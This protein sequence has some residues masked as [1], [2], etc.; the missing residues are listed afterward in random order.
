MDAW[1]GWG[2][3]LACLMTIAC[4]SGPAGPDPALADLQAIAA[5]Q[6]QAAIDCDCPGRGDLDTCMTEQDAT[7]RARQVA[8]RADGLTYDPSCAADLAAAIEAQGCSAP[9]TGAAHP[10]TSYCAPFHGERE[11]GASCTR[12]D[13]LVSDCAQGLTCV[14][15]ACREPCQVFTGLRVGEV[16]SDPASGESLDRCAEGLYCDERCKPLAGP[17]ESCGACV[18]DYYCSY[19]GQ[20]TRCLER[21]DEGESCDLA[22]C[23]PG[24]FCDYDGAFQCRALANAGE[25]CSDRPCVDGLAC[26]GTCRPPVGEGESCAEAACRDGLLCDYATTITCV[27]PPSAGSPCISD[28]CEAS[29]VCDFETYTCRLGAVEGDPCTGHAQ[30]Q[31]RYCPAGRCAELPAIG[32]SCEGTLRCAIGASCDGR[33]C[34]PSPTH[35]PA[36]CVY[37]GW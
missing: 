4:A 3:A 28:R 21:A 14:D 22:S 26:N 24:L 36:V 12:F 15:G 35:G 2:A 10:C 32:E 30:C 11:L 25:S 18:E 29:A 6:C 20:T 17:G 37:Q 7:W 13:D 23:K 27:A 8:G 9:G 16:C 34:R 31:S 5:A 1:H 19:D 33:V